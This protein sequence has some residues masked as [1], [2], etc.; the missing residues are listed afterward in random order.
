MRPYA[1][2][3]ITRSVYLTG[4]LST[5]GHGDEEWHGGA[6]AMAVRAPRTDDRHSTEDMRNTNGS[7]GTFKR[8]ALILPALLTTASMHAQTPSVYAVAME[9]DP[10]PGYQYFLSRI[11]AGAGTVAH[12][13]QLPVDGFYMGTAFMNF[14]DN[15]MFVGRDSADLT[16]HLYEVDTLGTV[17]N[18]FPATNTA[19]TST[20]LLCVFQSRK[21]PYYYGIRWD[22]DPLH[23]LVKIDPVQ[24]TAT[25]MASLPM[26]DQLSQSTYAMDGED[27]LYFLEANGITGYKTLF[28]A[29]PATGLITA[30]DSMPFPAHLF[31]LFYD[32]EA[33]KLFGFYNSSGAFNVQGS[34][35]VEIDQSG[36]IV[37][38]GTIISAGGDFW[39]TAF[40]TLANGNYLQ[41]NTGVS[42]LQL[43]PADVLGGTF[44][45]T[46]GTI[47][48]GDHKLYATVPISCGYTY[49][50]SGETQV[51]GIA[52][53][54]G[55][56]Q[57]VPNPASDQVTLVTPTVAVG[58]S[59]QLMDLAGRVVAQG[60]IEGPS[61]VLDLRALTSGTYHLMIAIGEVR[62]T[63]KLVK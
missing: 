18:A 32:C 44:A 10:V 33:D 56:W 36:A 7:M 4:A 17:L 12:V 6:D 1:P 3:R 23:E 54:V 41:R 60:R 45:P 57:L 24:G 46:P 38:T 55:A 39:T 30:T 42:T 49:A 58:G 2:V 63:M 40:T 47:A 22:N 11:D 51:A 14:N 9:Y 52:G 37:H 15:Y 61:T 53:D 62:R 34:E 28:R 59:Y 35:W 27:R 16:Y 43:D 31:N 5:A 48:A 19:G 25:V 13:A 21:C 29:D 26:P 8:V 50:C 20:N